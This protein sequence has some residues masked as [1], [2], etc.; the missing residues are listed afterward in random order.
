MSHQDGFAAKGQLRFGN[1]FVGFARRAKSRMT[2][3]DAALG[4]PELSEEPTMRIL[5]LGYVGTRSR[6]AEDW[7]RFGP[8][9][10]GTPVAT[11]DG[12]EVT[13]LRLDER[14]WRI[15]VHPGDRD[16]LAYVGWEVSGPVDLESA[17]AELRHAGLGAE[18]D[19]LDERAARGV[20]GLVGFDDPWG[21]RHELFFGAR[22]LG[23]FRPTREISGFVTGALGLGH[24]VLVLPDLEQAVDF[25]TRV[26]GFQ[27]SDFIDVPFPLAFFH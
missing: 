2:G 17:L 4:R 21:N 7:K 1:E 14:A 6:R 22:S 27:L 25:F 26:M 24:V 15:A 11:D 8:E 20:E 23:S 3:S 16:E 12:A 19:S 13:R 9:I 18:R 10:L 5:S